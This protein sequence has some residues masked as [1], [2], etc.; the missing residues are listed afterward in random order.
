MNPSYDFRISKPD[1]IQCD[2]PATKFESFTF[3]KRFQAS[4]YYS[5]PLA[6]Q[7]AASWYGMDG[8]FWEDRGKD[9]GIILENGCNRWI[10]HVTCTL[11]F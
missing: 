9:S 7:I 8:V 11:F 6:E 4:V 10:S 5:R 1:G 2:M 3:P